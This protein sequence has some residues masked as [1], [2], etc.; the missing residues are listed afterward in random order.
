MP[1]VF[2]SAT[3]VALGNFDPDLFRLESLVECK[4]ISSKDADRSKV[5]A[6][7]PT[8]VAHFSLPWGELLLLQDRLQTTATEAPFI[9]IADLVVQAMNMAE[10]RCS[11]QAFGINFEAH[12][13]VGSMAARDTLAV[14]FAPP[15]P[16]GEWGQVVRA[17]MKDE[18]PELHGGVAVLTMRE[19]FRAGD[20]RGWYDVT[21]TGSERVPNNTGVKFFSNHHHEY[22]PELPKE[23]PERAELRTSVLL[24]ALTKS[25]DDSIG[26]AERIFA[27]ALA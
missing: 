5:M 16:W 21:L 18:K 3:I 15:D 25:F 27:K 9:R 7:L 6:L 1:A 17:S 8:R 4:A 22:A 2:S 10:K 26:K 23:A 24:T 14:K 13:D 19:R 12:F 11:I 20:I